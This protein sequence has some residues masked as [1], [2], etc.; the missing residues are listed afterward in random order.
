[1]K[2]GAVTKKTSEL[3]SVW[4]PFQLVD[5][6]MRAV[7]INDTDRSKFIRAALREKL[8]REKIPVLEGAAK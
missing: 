8:H 5:G 7:V 1:M 6:L 2:R 3:V 4:V